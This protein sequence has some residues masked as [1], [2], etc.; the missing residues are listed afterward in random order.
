MATRLFSRACAATISLLALTLAGC[1]GGGSGSNDTGNTDA[2]PQVSGGNGGGG[3]GGGSSTLGPTVDATQLA[4]LCPSYD[5][6]S[7]IYSHCKASTDAAVNAVLIDI[8]TW[9]AAHSP[10]DKVAT[11]ADAS[12]AVVAGDACSFAIEPGLGIFMMTLKNNSGP[13]VAW[14]GSAIDTIQVDTSG[15]IVYMSASTDGSGGGFTNAAG[16]AEVNFPGA[17]GGS[18]SEAVYGQDSKFVTCTMK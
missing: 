7:R 18:I 1:G 3:T 12:Y 4:K 17:T 14:S 5:A 13:N 15:V 6:A 8:N 10:T 16:K 9:I 2:Q 11:G